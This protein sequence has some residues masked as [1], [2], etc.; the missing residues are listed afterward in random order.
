MVSVFI[1]FDIDE[2]MSRGVYSSLDLAKE[3]AEAYFKS[4]PH[5]VWCV[6]EYELDGTPSMSFNNVYQN[7]DIKGS[8][9]RR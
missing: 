2:M 1:I 7:M 4:R 5:A 9:D 3:R 8:K 6:Q